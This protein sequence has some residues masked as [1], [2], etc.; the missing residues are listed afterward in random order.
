MAS[1]HQDRMTVELLSF[2]DGKEA[3]AKA[4]SFLYLQYLEGD[5]VGYNK[6]EPVFTETDVTNALRAVGLFL[7][8]LTCKLYWTY[9]V[10]LFISCL[11]LVCNLGVYYCRTP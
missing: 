2:S 5:S 7:S 6:M 10:I 3:V 4:A 1:L 8:S 9:V 11:S